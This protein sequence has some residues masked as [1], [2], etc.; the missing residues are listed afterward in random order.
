MRN[1]FATPFWKNAL[2]SLPREVRGR[3]A[4]Q[5]QAA[6]RWELALGR[7]IETLSRARA[8]FGRLFHAPTGAH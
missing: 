6:E 1:E 3:Y 8:G 4:L 5:L 2:N 7:V